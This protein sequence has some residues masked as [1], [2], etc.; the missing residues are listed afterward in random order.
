M[1]RGRRGAEK[2]LTKPPHCLP[3]ARLRVNNVTVTPGFASVCDGGGFEEDRFAHRP[4]EVA[5]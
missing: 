4:G 1:L 3:G 2:R 5:A